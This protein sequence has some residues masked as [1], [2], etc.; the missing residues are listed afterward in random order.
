MAQ[1]STSA[2][3]EG[4]AAGLP[5]AAFTHSSLAIA[6]CDQDFTICFFNSAIDR[7]VRH[8]AT[9]AA[10]APGGLQGIAL[11]RLLEVGDGVSMA[12]I[13]S[14]EGWSAVA[15]R[16]DTLVSVEA[17]RNA[18]DTSGWLIIARALPA[19][20]AQ[21]LSDQELIGRSNKLTVRER[22]VMLAL[23]EGDGNKAIAKRLEISP[24]TVEF[25]R[26]R[27][28]QRFDAKSV[29]DLVRRVTTDARLEAEFP[30]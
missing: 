14:P 26:A 10:N 16:G 18:D 5:H 25:H 12:E 17:F 11:L 2:R 23:R 3:A 7:L 4:P 21:G 28:M 19:A 20:S 29:V 13:T 22:E 27:I 8:G 9:A 6:I 15:P 30:R 1:R 24:R